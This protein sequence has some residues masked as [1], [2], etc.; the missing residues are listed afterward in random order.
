MAK[1]E[2]VMTL[3]YDDSPPTFRRGAKTTLEAANRMLKLLSAI[4]REFTGKRSPSIPWDVNIYSFADRAVI[5]FH[6]QHPISQDLANLALIAINQ[7]I[8]RLGGQP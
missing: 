7:E 3:V 8:E 6:A 4:E 1:G 2:M 5:E